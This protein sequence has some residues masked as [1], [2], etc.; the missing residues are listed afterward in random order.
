MEFYETPGA[1]LG[2]RGIPSV[3]SDLLL[4][5]PR[6]SEVENEEIDRRIFSEPGEGEELD[7]LREDWHAY[8]EPELH[9]Y[10]L[11]TRQIVETDLR[12]MVEEED[13]LCVEFPLKHADAWL[14]ALNQAR[15]A[16]A[17]LHGMDEN[18]LSASGPHE[19]QNERDL[20]LFQIHF[21]GMIQQWLLEVLE[22][23]EGAEE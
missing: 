4:Q 5:I 12:R 21:Y 16:L 6:W 1:M 7:G 17:A 23:G 14:N 18:E 19:V 9:E 15:L 20:A 11:S 10:F 2:I 3:V 22:G 13:G 8:V